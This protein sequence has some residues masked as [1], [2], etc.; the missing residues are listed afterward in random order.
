MD[1][2]HIRRHL[3]SLVVREIQI[4]TAVICLYTPTKVTLIKKTDVNKI[5]EHESCRHCCGRNVYQGGNG[6]TTLGKRS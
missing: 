4:K 3:I 6:K 2:K 5:Q 1:N